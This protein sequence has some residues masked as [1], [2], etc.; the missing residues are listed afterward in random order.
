MWRKTAEV[1]KQRGG[2]D[3]QSLPHV[4]WPVP[5]TPV[6]LGSLLQGPRDTKDSATSCPWRSFT[7]LAFW[8]G[9]LLFR[10][11]P[12]KLL[13]F[14]FCFFVDLEIDPSL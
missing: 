5:P 10:I 8:E 9:G 7:R 14:S 1:R 6:S 12:G 2:S 13:G 3:K 11:L 4:P